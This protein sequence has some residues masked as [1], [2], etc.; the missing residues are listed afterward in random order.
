MSTQFGWND[1][2]EAIYRSQNGKFKK[3]EFEL[4]FVYSIFSKLN[5]IKINKAGIGLQAYVTLQILCIPW[6][7]SKIQRNVYEKVNIWK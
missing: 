7:Q 3:Y 1:I 6:I 5:Q 2:Y 4:K